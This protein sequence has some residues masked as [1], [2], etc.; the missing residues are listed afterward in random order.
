MR[1]RPPVHRP[2]WGIAL[3]VQSVGRSSFKWIN[4]SGKNIKSRFSFSK[5]SIRKKDLF[6]M[7]HALNRTIMVHKGNTA[8]WPADWILI[9]FKTVVGRS[10]GS[11]RAKAPVEQVMQWQQVAIL[12]HHWNETQTAHISFSS[13]GWCTTSATHGHRLRNHA[14]TIFCTMT[15]AVAH[16]VTVQHKQ[17]AKQEVSAP[18]CIIFFHRCLNLQQYCTV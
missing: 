11:S 10:R 6:E 7:K 18:V 4:S 8:S 17:M 5:T 9:A 14:A 1:A 15:A 3:K 13:S 16:Q 12:L 2:K